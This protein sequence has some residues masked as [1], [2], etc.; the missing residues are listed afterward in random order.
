MRYELRTEEW[1]IVLILVNIFALLAGKYSIYGKHF[2]SKSVMAVVIAA[3]QAAF[4][5]I[6]YAVLGK[7]VI[8]AC[9]MT[10][11]IGSYVS[12]ALWD[13][14]S[15]N[16]ESLSW[17]KKLVHQAF[18]V[19]VTVS[20]LLVVSGSVGDANIMTIEGLIT[21]IV[22]GVLFAEITYSVCKRK[23]L[24]SPAWR[25]VRLESRYDS[26]LSSTLTTPTSDRIIRI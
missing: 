22:I 21:Q 13:S 12:T 10:S 20:I 24:L 3:E 4:F 2:N 19:I 18:Y 6:A 1:G 8:E 25:G 23:K 17:R 5:G 7:A 14:R 15:F 9:L 26:R 16:I 11:V